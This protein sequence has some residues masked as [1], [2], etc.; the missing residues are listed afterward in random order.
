MYSDAALAMNLKR[1][2]EDIKAKKTDEDII[3]YKREPAYG[4]AIDIQLLADVNVRRD[5][6]LSVDHTI[7]RELLLV[8]LG[9]ENKLN[10]LR[11]K[12][13]IFLIIN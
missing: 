8:R 13:I 11:G 10:L 12:G 9:K 1:W 4:T 6:G 3:K 7:L 5:A 2:K